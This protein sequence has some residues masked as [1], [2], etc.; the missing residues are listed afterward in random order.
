MARILHKTYNATYYSSALAPGG[1]YDLEIFRLDVPE[2]PAT[3]SDRDFV[4]STYNRYTYNI[5]P[6]G[7]VQVNVDS[8]LVMASANKEMPLDLVV[9]D[10]RLTAPC[11]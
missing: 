11:P 8:Q 9:Q 6:A 5:E 3:I 4:D 10:P 2:K 7:T 1:L